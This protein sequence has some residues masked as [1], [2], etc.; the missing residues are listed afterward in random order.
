MRGCRWHEYRILKQIAISK[1]FLN[2]F[3]PFGFK[4]LVTQP[5][6]LTILSE[7]SI[8]HVLTKDQDVITRVPKADISDQFGVLQERNFFVERII[9]K[10]EEFTFRNFK[11]AL[12]KDDYCC[13]FLF[14]LL[15]E[16]QK[17]NYNKKN[18]QELFDNLS[19]T[20]KNQKDL[21]FP[22][23]T[24]QLV[25]KRAFRNWNWRHVKICI[26]K[27]QKLFANILNNQNEKKW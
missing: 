13:K 11:N 22:E 3:L 14:K 24:S 6:K 7:P 18:R 10:T 17:S 23:T 16:L 8:D 26:K 15:H 25:E 21:Y 1:T 2:T 19:R 12:K 9:A 20:L 27:R 4:K 5:T